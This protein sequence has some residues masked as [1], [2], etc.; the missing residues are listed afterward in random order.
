MKRA[1]T[2]YQYGSNLYPMPEWELSPRNYINIPIASSPSSSCSSSFGSNSASC[3]GDTLYNYSILNS[4]Q[5]QTCIE[6]K[7]ISLIELHGHQS[8]YGDNY[9]FLGQWLHG[10][11]TNVKFLLDIYTNLIE[12]G[13]N[14][15]AFYDV[16]EI[17]L[18]YFS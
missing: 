2:I 13:I 6:N 16:M 18:C 15:T 1:L 9:A 7:V 11:R 5:L 12:Y 4:V 17:F 3:L 8:I 14:G 10:D